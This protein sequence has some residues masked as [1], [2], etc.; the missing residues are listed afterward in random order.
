[1]KTQAVARGCDVGQLRL[2]FGGLARPIQ[3]GFER[4]TSPYR[5]RPCRDANSS[6]QQAG[7]LCAF[8]AQA[9]K[10]HCAGDVDYPARAIALEKTAWRPIAFVTRPKQG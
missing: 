9:Q 3:D 1:M 7:W 10:S 4:S 2:N 6:Q 5:K 8:H